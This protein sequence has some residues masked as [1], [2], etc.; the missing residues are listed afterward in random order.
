MVYFEPIIKHSPYTPRDYVV[1]KCKQG[2]QRAGPSEACEPMRRLEM[3][4]FFGTDMP[5]RTWRPCWNE[6]I[7]WRWRGVFYNIQLALTVA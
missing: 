1:K 3:R 4:R 2:L 6:A 7:E 5:V